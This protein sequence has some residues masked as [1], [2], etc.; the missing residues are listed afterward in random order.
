M[1]ISDVSINILLTG[2]SRSGKSTFINIVNNSLLSLENCEKSS[3]TTK[4][5]EYK[6]YFGKNRSEKDGYLKFIDTAGFNCQTNKKNDRKEFS[7]LSQINKSIFNIIEEYKQKTPLENIHFV[8]FFFIEGSPLEGTE[9]VLEMFSKE[10]YKVLFI[11]NKSTN[12]ED[13]GNTTD[14]KSTLK[15]LK[16]NHLNNLAIKENIIP[17]NIIE[18][19]NTRGYGINT[20]FKRIFDILKETNKFYNDE[21]LYNELKEW[22]ENR[23]QNLNKEER[24]KE[25]NEI[26]KKLSEGN[27]LFKEYVA[28]VS[29]I[30]KLEQKANHDKKLYMAITSSQ[31][32][33]PIPYSDLA[34]TPALQAKLIHTI[35]TD[36]GISLAEI[37]WE[38]FG[39]YL[40]GGGLREISHYTYNKASKKIFE[41]T[42]KGCLMQLG[43][44]LMANQTGK[45]AA[46]SMKFVPFL[47]FIVGAGIGTFINFFSTKQIG[48]KS[49]LFCEK[50]LR[51]KG[52]IGFFLKNFEIF[53]NVFKS[54]ENLSNK[55][56][57]WDYKMKIIKKD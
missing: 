46:E 31:A 3:V 49:I 22:Y 18:S 15:F 35:L 52:F 53:N 2:I 17:C 28:D 25:S 19:K 11:I 34:L 48:D 6:I 40:L 24:E 38:T 7:D 4:S 23:N 50:Y 8:L 41:K 13:K 9:K 36:F 16:N 27:E 21:K 45:A 44:M 55:E 37:N 51:E 42:A 43:K 20:I 47:G 5:T 1:E 33:I 12:D 14:I 29:L 26:K 57:W 54:I 32:F 56:N 30:N 10:N 39:N